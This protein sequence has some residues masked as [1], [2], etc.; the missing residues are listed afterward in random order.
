MRNVDW[1]EGEFKGRKGPVATEGRTSS[2]AIAA[3]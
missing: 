3:E 1:L 2:S